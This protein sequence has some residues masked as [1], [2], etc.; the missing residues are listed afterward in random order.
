KQFPEGIPAH[1]TDALRFTFAALA[2]PSRDIRFDLARVA[3]YRNFC[4]KLWN[5]ARFVT[6]MGEQDDLH[7]EAHLSVADRWIRSR[8]GRALTTVEK[9]LAE[10]RFDYAANALYEF[11]WYEYCDWYLELTK[12]VLQAETPDAAAQRGARR[13]LAEVLEALQRA[14]HPIMPFI[15][16]EIWQRAAPLAGCP[17]ETVMNSSY[18]LPE[19]FPTDEAS[20][21]EIGWIQAFVLAVRQ[22]RGEMNIAPS[23]RIPV[24]L[25]G[26]CEQDR[27]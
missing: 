21:R 10:Y 20:E 6:L 11:T 12:P 4:N 14:L 9:A 13:T 8:F 1:G 26:A 22:I 2:S 7:A 27:T 15:T 18:P 5:A 17:G 24:L 25:K 19:Q 3:G 23:R 16:E